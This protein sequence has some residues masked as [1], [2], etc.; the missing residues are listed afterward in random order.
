MDT[1]LELLDERKIKEMPREIF[2]QKFMR[3]IAR[4]EA[5]GQ[6][7]ILGTEADKEDKEQV[8][9]DLCRNGFT[10]TNDEELSEISHAVYRRATSLK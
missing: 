7:F 8:L 5:F 2:L 4:S 1:T 9:S 10:V 3:D 6:L